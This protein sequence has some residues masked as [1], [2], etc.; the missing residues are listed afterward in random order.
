[1]IDK[2]FVV[3][4]I[5]GVKENEYWLLIHI[6]EAKTPSDWE[7]YQSAILQVV[8]DKA[9]CR[10]FIDSWIT[11][12]WVSRE[13]HVFACSMDGVIHHNSSGKWEKINLGVQYS[14]NDIWGFDKDNLYCCG[15]NGALFHKEGDTFQ[16]IDTGLT[17]DFQKIRGTS[18]SNL[19]II[20][21][22]GSI[23]FFNGKNWLEVDSPTNNFWMSLLCVSDEEIYICGENGVLFKG[24]HDQWERIDGVEFDL[25]DLAFFDNQVLVASEDKGLLVIQDNSLSDYYNKIKVAGMKV[26]DGILLAFY[27]DSLY[28]YDGKKWSRIKF[29]FSKLISD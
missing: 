19:Y 27:L 16:L 29:D 9:Y 23:I 28:K 6:E 14:L 10:L 4:E 25:W 2:K 21:A 26:I 13:G 15:L 20:G 5:D 22:A 7:T 12:I 18:Y 11:S 3:Y 1:M 24:Y 17:K 8:N